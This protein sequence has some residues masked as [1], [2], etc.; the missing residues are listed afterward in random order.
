MDWHNSLNCFQLQ[1][2]FL[3]HNQ[4]DPITAVELEA[5]VRNWKGDLTL[6]G[7]PPHMQFVAEALLISGLQQPRTEMPLNFNGCSHDL[8]GSR[9]SLGFALS[10]SLC[11]CGED[12]HS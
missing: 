9:V 3:P 6:E 11:I 12:V 2:H 8:T 4:V 1:N 10:V 5:L 7:Q